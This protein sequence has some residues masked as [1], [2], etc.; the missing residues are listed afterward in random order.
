MLDEIIISDINSNDT[1]NA[2]SVIMIKCLI[3]WNPSLKLYAP[4]KN[5]E[6]KSLCKIVEINKSWIRNILERWYQ[7]SMVA[8]VIHI[9]INEK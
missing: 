1:Q 8:T 2:R 7:Q 6:C 5:Y 3:N 9:L 4:G